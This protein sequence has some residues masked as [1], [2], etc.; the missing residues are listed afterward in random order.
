M[1]EADALDIVQAAIWTVIVASGPAVL[2]AM[3]VGVVIAFIQALTQVQEMTLTFVPKILA[4]MV[5]AAISAPFVGA[6]ISIF[7][8]IIFSRIQS[9][10]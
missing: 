8:D 2:A 1:N 10:F 3:V 6:Q 7:T 5:T 9:G 4:V